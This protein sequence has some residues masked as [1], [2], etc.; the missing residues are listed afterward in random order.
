MAD[1]PDDLRAGGRSA[2]PPPH[3]FQA[4]RLTAVAIADAA[5]ATAD[6]QLPSADLAPRR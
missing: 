5:A 3:P 2:G 6:L 4:L 1:R